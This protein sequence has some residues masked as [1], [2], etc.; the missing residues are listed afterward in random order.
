MALKKAF[1]IKRAFLRRFCFSEFFSNR[2]KFCFDCLTQRKRADPAL[3]MGQLAIQNSERLLRNFV[4]DRCLRSARR[5][6]FAQIHTGYEQ[7]RMGRPKSSR[8][9]SISR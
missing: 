2:S 3:E 7:L 6:C 1:L 9:I 4:K 5:S 8:G